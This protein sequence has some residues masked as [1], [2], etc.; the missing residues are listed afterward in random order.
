MDILG[1]IIVPILGR[2]ESWSN[3]WQD[4]PR[5][6]SLTTESN[7][8]SQFKAKLLP[9]DLGELPALHSLGNL[10]CSLLGPA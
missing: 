7:S 6:C 5:S 10:K 2:K 4:R 3:R 1:T 8:L 9:G